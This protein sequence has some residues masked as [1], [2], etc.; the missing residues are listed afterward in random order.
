M[1]QIEINDFQLKNLKE[2][3]NFRLRNLKKRNQPVVLEKLELEHLNES[4]L[5]T[6]LPF[7]NS[8]K[9]NASTAM[10]VFYFKTR[11][12]EKT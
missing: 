10:S 9:S 11:E 5:E 1:T 2:A 12:R 8:Q 6:S 4:I 7:F 3:E